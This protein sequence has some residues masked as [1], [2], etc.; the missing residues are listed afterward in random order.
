[1]NLSK[2]ENNSGESFHFHPF[3]YTLSAS[4]TKF[5]IE[6]LIIHEKSNTLKVILISCYIRHML[7]M[8]SI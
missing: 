4:I 7:E 5:T 3:L 2:I 1:M 8:Y 6:K